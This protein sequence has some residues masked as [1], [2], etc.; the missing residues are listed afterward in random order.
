MGTSISAV[1]KA[2]NTGGLRVGTEGHSDLVADEVTCD[3]ATLS[4]IDIHPGCFDPLLAMLELVGCVRMWEEDLYPG[5]GPY[6][7]RLRYR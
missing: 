5:W 7:A 3:L 2:A 4:S 6:P 1:V